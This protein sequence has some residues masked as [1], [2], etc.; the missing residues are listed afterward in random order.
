M[1]VGVCREQLIYAARSWRS[2]GGLPLLL[3]NVLFKQQKINVVLNETPAHF[4]E[5]V[6]VFKL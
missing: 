3:T 6:Y 1:R 4:Q 5:L 2:I